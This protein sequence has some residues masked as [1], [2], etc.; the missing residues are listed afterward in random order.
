MSSTFGG[1]QPQAVKRAGE[2]AP[3][4]FDFTAQ[5]GA[6]ETISTQVV[7]ATVY[8]GTDANPS[9]IVS[10]AA[11]AS[12]KI[13]SQAITAGVSGV[14]YQLVCTITT[15]LSKTLQQSSYLAVVPPLT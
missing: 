10:G 13:V 5:L 8:S 9:A 4:P 1:L 3:V 2:T 6:A 12:G 7:A 15:S 14:I 11:S